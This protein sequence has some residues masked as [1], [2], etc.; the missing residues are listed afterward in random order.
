MEFV[1]KAEKLWIKMSLL[2]CQKSINTV[3]AVCITKICI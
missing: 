3:G 2:I 1:V